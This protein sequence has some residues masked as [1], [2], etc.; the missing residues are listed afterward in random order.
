MRYIKAGTLC[1]TLKE[2]LDIECSDRQKIKPDTF[3]FVVEDIIYLERLLGND[4][5][6]GKFLCENRLVSVRIRTNLSL[7]KL[8]NIVEVDN[9]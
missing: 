5:Y 1:Q 9:E 3:V 4:H 7:D 6:H 8:F 2:I